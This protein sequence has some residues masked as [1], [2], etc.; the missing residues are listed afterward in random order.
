LT[1]IEAQVEC[2]IIIDIS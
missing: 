1:D 2:N